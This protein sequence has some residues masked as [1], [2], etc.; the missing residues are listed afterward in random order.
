MNSKP[1]FRWLTWGLPA[2]LAALAFAPLIAEADPQPTR[3][4]ADVKRAAQQIDKLVETAL[5]EAGLKPAP[6]ADEATFLRRTYLAIVGRIPTEAEIAAYAKA[7]SSEKSRHLIDE[8]LASKGHESHMFNWWADLLRARGRLAQRASGEPYIHWLKSS[9]AR[10]KSY[11][12]MVKELLTASGPVHQRGNGAT[13]YM[14]RD[15]NMP[16]DNMSNTIRLFLGSRVECAQCHNHPFDKWTQK[17][18]FEM[19]AFTGGIRYA[20][21][22][23][24]DPR[25]RELAKQAQDKWGRNGVRALRRTLE[26][27]YIGIFGSGTGMARL[28]KDYQY[29]DAKPLDWTVASPL[30]DPP[31]HVNV[32]MP[33]EEELRRRIRGGTRRRRSS[34]CSSAFVPRRRTRAGRSR[35]G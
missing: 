11:D 32:E 30:F 15:R 2:L 24:E 7:S 35:S 14:M 29:D 19:V 25:A 13:G 27:T 17:Q 31:V 10:N 33:N 3:D 20:R 12:T 18:Y 1:S 4:V 9:I 26:P 5:R 8:L 16:E 6:L 28:P 34:A 23:R 21:N 22:P